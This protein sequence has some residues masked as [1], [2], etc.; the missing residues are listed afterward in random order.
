[1]KYIKV[2]V[3]TRSLPD[4]YHKNMEHLPNTC[5][6]NGRD[7]TRLKDNKTCDRYEDPHNSPN[8]PTHYAGLAPLLLPPP[9][10]CDSTDGMFASTM[11]LSSSQKETKESLDEQDSRGGGLPCPDETGEWRSWKEVGIGDCP[12]LPMME[13]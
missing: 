10:P 13:H 6:T 4:S 9:G 2:T 5:E 1:M 11:A 12:K 7:Y 8:T 3:A